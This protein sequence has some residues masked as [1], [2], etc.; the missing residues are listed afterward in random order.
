VLTIDKGA[1]LGR[2]QQDPGLA[3]RMLEKLCHRIR[4]ERTQAP[5]EVPEG[6]RANR[7][8]PS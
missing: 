8:D 5:V 1:L 7:V 6:P 4:V 3:F 2:I